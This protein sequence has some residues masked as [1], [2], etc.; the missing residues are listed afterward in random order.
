[1]Y[2]ETGRARGLFPYMI[3]YRM[4]REERFMNLTTER[5]TLRPFRED[6]VQA[7]Y[8]YSRDEPVG[9]NAGWKPHES[10]QESDDILHLV[11]LDQPGVWAIERRAADRLGRVDC[12]QRAAIRLGAL[13]RLCAR[14]PLLGAGLY[15]RGGSRGTPLWIRADVARPDLSDLLSGQSRVPPR[16]GEMRFSIRGHAAP[17]RTALQR[18]DQGPSAL[19][20]DT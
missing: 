17:R 15:D 16:A 18:R 1:M 14:R 7:L 5:L 3:A 13:A 6:D 10:L 2:M 19:F 20:S 8:E 12:G 11:F 9:R 4:M